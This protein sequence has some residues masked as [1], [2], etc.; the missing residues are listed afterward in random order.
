MSEGVSY[1]DDGVLG[2]QQGVSVIRTVSLMCPF[3]TMRG[4]L[5]SRL[6]PFGPPYLLSPEKDQFGSNCLFPGAVVALRAESHVS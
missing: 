4:N 6:P 3:L 5:C 2:T 1:S